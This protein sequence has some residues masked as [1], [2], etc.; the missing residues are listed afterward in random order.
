MSSSKPVIALF[1]A[2]GF[3][4]RNVT[5]VFTKAA[6]E[7]TIASLRIFSSRPPSDPSLQVFAGDNV[8][9]LQT[10]FT[11]KEE[12][13]QQLQGVNAVVCMLGN[14]GEESYRVK[15]LLLEA[16]VAAGVQIY[17]PSEFGA[18]HIATPYGATNTMLTFKRK[19]TEDSICQG[20]KTLSIHNGCFLE[21][22]F[23]RWFGMDS[24]NNT[25]SFVGDGT[26]PMA[27]TS[28]NDVAHFTLSAVLLAHKDPK[29]VPDKLHVYSANLTQRQYA[30]ELDAAAPAGTPPFKI[31]TNP[32]D[33]AKADYEIKR[34]HIPPHM[35]GPLLPILAAEGVFDASKSNANEL[36][37]PGGSI[38]PIK[39][40]QQYAREVHGRPWK[41]VDPS[42]S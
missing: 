36:L 11:S 20:I 40:F 27:C 32:L 14:Q 35:L 5:P 37:N 25:Y 6:Q 18:D 33:Q 34:H 17:V 24:A 42:F 15:D 7:G 23:C 19:H 3:L 22:A 13:A 10:N 26:T 21:I 41:G 12:L 9:I 31:I 16:L 29:S 4:G 1:G 8:Q 38:W 39:T 28:L 30:Q 2:T